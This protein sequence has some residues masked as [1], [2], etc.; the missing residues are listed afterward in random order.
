MKRWGIVL[1][2]IILLV[3]LASVVVFRN[4]QQSPSPVNTPKDNTPG[5]LSSLQIGPY[6]WSPETESLES[7]LKAINL[8]AL[9]SEGEAL[10][11]HQHLDLFIDS[12]QVPIPEGI[13]INKQERFFAPIHVHDNT[14]VIHVESPTVQTYTLGQ[15]FDVWGVRFSD[16]CLGGYCQEGEKK[17]LV[18]VNGQP[19][20]G[21]YSRITLEPNQEIAIVYGLPSE[22]PQ[23][24]P[25]TY[26]FPEGY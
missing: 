7:R 1:L 2:I 16:Q 24:I 19:V 22:V 14:G 17:L 3:S 23:T 10:H 11:T 26:S 5:N 15:F 6:P 13:G 4:Q 20:S 12:Q 18:Y 8:P 25:S 21:N 9:T